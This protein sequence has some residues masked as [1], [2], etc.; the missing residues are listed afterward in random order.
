MN[1]AVYFD[2]VFQFQVLLKIIFK[3]FDLNRRR[4]VPRRCSWCPNCNVIH[5][6]GT[7]DLVI[8]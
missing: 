2:T 3:L 7:A 6:L 1:F 5:S 8:I 4:G